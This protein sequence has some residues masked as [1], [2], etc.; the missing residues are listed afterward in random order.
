MNNDPVEPFDALIIGVGQSGKPL[1]TALAKKGW[2][3][4]IIERNQVGGSCI[5][6]GCTPTKTLLSSAEMAFQARRAAEFG[7]DIA[8]IGVD[9]KAV[10]ERKDKVVQKFRDGINDSFAETENLTFIQGEARFTAPREIAVKL[11]AG[12]QRNLTANYIFIDCGT[13]PKKPDLPGLDTVSWVTS[14][15]LMDA[16]ELPEHL[17]ILG[18]GYIGVEF[19]QMF[20]RFGSEVTIIERGDQ[21]L[22]REDKDIAD[23][24]TKILEDEGVRVMTNTSVEQV[25]RSGDNGVTLALKTDK[26]PVLLTG[27]KLLVV[28]GTTP[29]TAALNLTAAG[30]TTDEHGFIQV[31]DKL[32][33]SQPGVYALGDIKGGPA[34]THISYDDYRVVKKNLL[35]GG[36]ASIVGRPVPYT[37]FTDPQLGRV[38]L[39][40]TEAR[41]Q[42]K[43][44]KVASMPMSSVARAIETNRTG[45][46]MKVIIDADTDQILGAAILGMEGGEVM[47]MLQIAMMGNVTY[48]RLRDA[49]FAHPTLAEALNNVFSRVE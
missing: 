49:V 8:D 31:N 23:E 39:S 14:T 20:R 36:D 29:N 26:G 4:A 33:T 41:Q 22:S 5:N 18:G 21:L 11:P 25:S 37:I 46:L 10:I 35:E 38:G 30:I 42:G 44:I 7:I 13:H 47:T 45:G 1:A 28:T 32:E 34:F 17:L 27:T 24:L 48:P 19:S 9:F 2:R 12:G 3:T 15:E 6:Y 43:S 16:T 40:E